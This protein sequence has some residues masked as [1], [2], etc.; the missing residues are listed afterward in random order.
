MATTHGVQKLANRP[1]RSARPPSRIALWWTGVVFLCLLRSTSLWGMGFTDEAGFVEALEQSGLEVERFDFEDTPA[2]TVLED[3]DRLGSLAFDHA[4]AGG[5][6]NLA[7]TDGLPT[8]SGS[9]FLGLSAGP[10]QDRQIQHGDRATI[11]FLSLRD[12]GRPVRAFGLKVVSG[13]PLLAGDITISGGG[14]T[15]PNAARPAGTT[16]DDGRVYFLGLVA[17][18]SIDEVTLDYGFPQDAVAFL[19]TVDDIALGLQSAPA[20]PV[21]VRTPVA[22]ALLVLALFTAG[23]V[24]LSS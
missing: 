19:F 8:A 7:V 4:I 20:R 21:S 1:V 13:D 5:A 22:L 24:R 14:F 18:T 12:G 17:D 3:G 6:I 2:G 11:R 15:V 23:L 10:V 9:R 16:S